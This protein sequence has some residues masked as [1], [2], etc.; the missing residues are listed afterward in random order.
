MADRNQNVRKLTSCFGQVLWERYQEKLM[1]E[2]A[3]E[4]GYPE[5]GE[6]PKYEEY[7]L[8]DFEDNLPI[9]LNELNIYILKKL[10]RDENV[11]INT[12]DIDWDVDQISLNVFGKSIKNLVGNYKIILDCDKNHGDVTLIAYGAIVEKSNV[13]HIDMQGKEAS[14]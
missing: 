9:F 4:Y 1:N 7:K 12:Y 11:N 13:L 3:K 8:R 5:I 2:Y 10:A 14:C 6:E